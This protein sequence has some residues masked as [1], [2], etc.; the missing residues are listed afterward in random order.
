MNKKIN[1]KKYKKALDFTIY[2][3][4]RGFNEITIY[5]IHEPEPGNFQVYLYK[6]DTLSDDFNYE[7]TISDISDK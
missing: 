5:A 1:K 4:P 7:F 3:I 2:N 6:T